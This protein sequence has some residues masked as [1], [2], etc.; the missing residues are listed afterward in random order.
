MKPL[1]APSILSGNFGKLED[2]IKNT[3]LAGADWLHIDVMDGSFV[4]PIT[5]GDNMVKIAKQNCKIPLDIH[6]MIE[7]PE[8]HIDAFKNAGADLLTIHIE[9]TKDPAAALKKIR[10]SGMKAGLTLKPA[11]PVSEIEPFLELSDMILIMTVNPGWS[12][13]KFMPEGLQKIERIKSLIEQCHLSTIIEVDGGINK[14]TGSLCVKAGA[15]V[16]VAG[17]FVFEKT[18]RRQVIES[19]KTCGA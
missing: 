2:E 15:S 18:D 19:L 6:L 9:A 10:A 14:E 1:V 12:G 8:K 7:N 5:F 17:S 4:P 11:T 3:V 16:L 13:Q